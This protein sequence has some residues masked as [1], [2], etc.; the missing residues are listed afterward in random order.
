[1]SITRYDPFR[2]LRALQDEVNR[3]FSSSLRAISATRASRAAR[4]SRAWTSTRT[5]TRSCSRPSLPGMNREDFE[6]TVENNVMTLRG[7]RRFEKRDEGD[8]YHRVERAYGGVHALFHAAADR[9]GRNATAEYKNGVLRVTLRK[10]EEVKARRIEIDG[11]GAAERAEDHRGEGRRRATPGA[12]RRPRPARANRREGSRAGVHR[13]T[14]A[15][16]G[17]TR[18]G[19]ASLRAVPVLQAGVFAERVFKEVQSM[20]LD[21]FTLRGQEAIQ[22]SHRSWPSAIRTS[23][24]SRSICSLAMLEQKEGV[25]RPILGKIGANVQVVLNDVQ[26]AIGRFPKVQGGQQYFS[27]RTNTIFQEAQKEAEK[28]QD[29]YIS[30]EHLA[31]RDRGRE[32]RRRRAHPALERRHATTIS[33]RSS[34]RCAAA[35]AS[36]IRTPK[37]IFRRSKNTRR[38]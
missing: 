4:G 32:G 2:D 27:S 35:R 13:G 23:R 15:R 9:L 8:N 28:M 1:M 24:S 10:R 36:P 3:L 38:T 26:A 17:P 14:P 22:V 30:T 19:G 33:K 12:G 37:K 16:D 5:R 11:E 20:R 6:L 25:V 31:A 18:V 34:P 7:E 29:E 21:H